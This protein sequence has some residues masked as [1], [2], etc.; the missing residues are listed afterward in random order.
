[1]L[2]ARV[3]GNGHEGV[4]SQRQRRVLLV[5]LPFK[6]PPGGDQNARAGWSV[7]L[8]LLQHWLRGAGGC[9]GHAQPWVP[10]GRC[11]HT[12]IYLWDGSP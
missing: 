9:R 11:S 12:C 10:A 3:A 6:K 7:P 1:M 5:D 2:D 4:M 8:W